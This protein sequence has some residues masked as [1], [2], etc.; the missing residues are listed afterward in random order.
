MWEKKKKKKKMKKKKINGNNN[1]VI[2]GINISVP[3]IRTRQKSYRS[4]YFLIMGAEQR[5]CWKF[6]LEAGHHF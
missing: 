3:L 1:I 2:S 4:N 5:L 6:I